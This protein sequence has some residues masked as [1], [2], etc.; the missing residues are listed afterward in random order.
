MIS[1]E[2]IAN[3]NAHVNKS[4]HIEEHT[5]EEIDFNKNDVENDT[6][7]MK[8]TKSIKSIAHSILSIFQHREGGWG[9]VVVL[10]TGYSFGILIGMVNNY[11]LIYEKFVVIY[12]KTENH[13]V[14]S[15]KTKIAKIHF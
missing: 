2:K 9:W 8:S 7:S 12:N 14:Y 11:T 4:F 5:M 1:N 13:V 6:K 15:G 3:A 10:S